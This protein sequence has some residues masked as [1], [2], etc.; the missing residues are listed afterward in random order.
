LPA[1]GCRG[2]GLVFRLERRLR[3]RN[4][5]QPVQT[6]FLHRRLRDEQVAQVNRVKRAAK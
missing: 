6:Q 1:G 2:R 4:E 5:K 3:R